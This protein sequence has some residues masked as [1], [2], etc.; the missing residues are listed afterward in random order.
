MIVASA[1]S[2]LGSACAVTNGVPQRE[3]SRSR[4]APTVV[5]DNRAADSRA[6]DAIARGRNVFRFETFG[7]EGFWTDAVRAPQGMMAQHVTPMMAMKIGL[8][9]DIDSVDAATRRVLAEQ[10][11]TDPSG[12][13]SA[14]LNDPATS[15]KLLNA[16]AIIGLVVKPN[17]AGVMDVTRGAKVGVTCALCHTITDGSAFNMPNGG[18][19]GHRRDGLTNHNLD[20][21]AVL[22]TA[23]NSRALYPMLQLAL[24]ANGGKTFGRAPVGL[25][26]ASTEADVDAYLKNKQYYPVGMFDDSFDGNGEPMRVP[27]LFRQDLAAPFGSGGE[28]AKLDDFN[29][30]VYTALLDQTELT[31][32]GGRALLHKLGGAAGD[33]IADEYVKVLIA[34]G[35]TGYPFVKAAPRTDPKGQSAPIGLRVDEAKLRDLKA[36]VTSLAAPQGTGNARLVAEGR[37]VFVASGCTS[38]HNAANGAPATSAVIPMK[39]I[40]PGDNPTVLAQRTPPLN[41]IMDTP[42][43]TFDDKMAVVNASMRGK[44]RGVAVALLLDLARKPVFLHDSSVP[45]LDNLLDPSRGATA[46]HAFYIADASHRAAVVQFLRALDAHGSGPH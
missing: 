1:C 4:S 12:Q 32:P 18:S 3:A 33:E 16:N 46:P 29:N 41:P 5:G 30:L 8:S 35:V 44:E 9:V 43:N 23:A 14:L 10:L 17:A 26:S 20:V 27:P 37:R 34:T 40:F 38:C 25:T 28:F 7:N 11:R 19:V 2:L 31:T 6:A 36:F 24:R 39:R 21:G 13:T 45:S 42:G 15:I 22:A